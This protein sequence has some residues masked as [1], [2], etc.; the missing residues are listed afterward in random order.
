LAHDIDTCPVKPL[1]HG[2]IDK[3]LPGYEQSLLEYL[4]S[5]HHDMSTVR[6]LVRKIYKITQ[7]RRDR[8]DASLKAVYVTSPGTLETNLAVLNNGE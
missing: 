3:P 2:Y 7:E 8:L 5:N 4:Q 1:F 6:N